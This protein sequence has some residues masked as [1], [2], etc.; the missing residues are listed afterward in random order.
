MILWLFIPMKFIFFFECKELSYVPLAV[1]EDE[2]SWIIV[3]ILTLRLTEEDTDTSFLLVVTFF[4][5]SYRKH[6]GGKTGGSLS[7]VNN[8]GT[9]IWLFP[10]TLFRIKIGWSFEHST[11]FPYLKNLTI[12]SCLWYITAEH[13]LILD[14]KENSPKQ[15]SNWKTHTVK[16]YVKVCLPQDHFKY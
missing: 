2:N 12:F 15:L 4:I 11:L 10:G 7:Y 8:K 6:E 13:T 9:S 5:Y 14:R 1:I 3:T 16:L